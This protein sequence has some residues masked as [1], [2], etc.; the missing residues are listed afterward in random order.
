MNGKTCKRL[1]HLSAVAA[2]VAGFLALAGCNGSSS[3]GTG[4]LSL[5]VTDTPVDNVQ[6]VVVAFTS[7]EL[8]NAS[9]NTVTEKF[10]PAMT[11]DLLK[12]QK[13]AS[14]QLLSGVTVPAGNYQ[15]IRL[16]I[17][18]S[19]SYVMV[20]GNQDPLTLKVPSG[21]QSGLK[22]VSG[23]TVAQGSKMNFMVEF[24]LRKSLTMTGNPNTGAVT[25]ILTPALRLLNMEQV[26]SIS[27]TALPTISINGVSISSSS[28]SPAVY[29]YTGT[30]ATPEGFYTTASSSS[31]GATPLTSATLTPPTSTTSNYT[32]TVGFLEAGSYTLA[33]TCAAYDTTSSTAAFAYY[34]SPPATA[35]VTAK[36]TTTVDFQ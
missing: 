29:V 33:V 5:A 13:N 31:T 1:L 11:V 36:A 3:S 35:V 23:F 7:V 15:W 17:D 6:S 18:P 24:N 30:G 14:M 34:P 19:K 12:L 10:S 2:A 27:G 4:Q 16:N 28:C 9:G 32:Y 21:T 25:Y 8:H 22:L 26:G 20:N